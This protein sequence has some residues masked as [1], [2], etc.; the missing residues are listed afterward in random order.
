MTLSFALPR[1]SGSTLEPSSEP[2]ML[3]D[4]KYY[5]KGAGRAM[6]IKI[7]PTR[8]TLSL[9]RDSKPPHIIIPTPNFDEVYLDHEE[10]SPWS[11][12]EGADSSMLWD[13]LSIT[14]NTSL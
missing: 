5:E 2:I 7:I 6:H 1:F 4:P 14:S 9:K 12:E 13:S 10:F 3:Y 11:C 8:P